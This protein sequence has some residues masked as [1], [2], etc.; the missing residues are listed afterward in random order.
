MKKTLFLIIIALVCI[1]VTAENYQWRG[2]GEDNNW[3][4][5]ANWTNGTSLAH[6]TSPT[7]GDYI[8]L[9]S[10][11][12]A[13]G[14]WPVVMSG[15]NCSVYHIFM[16]MDSAAGLANFAVEN[17]ATLG[18]TPNGIHVGYVDDGE[19]NT[20]GNVTISGGLFLGDG[21]ADWGYAHGTMNVS[22]GIV[23]SDSLNFGMHDSSGNYVGGDGELF[24]MAGVLDAQV[25][26]G[27]SQSDSVIDIYG[28]EFKL[29]GDVRTEINA[30]VESK[31]IRGYSKN[32]AIVVAYDSGSNK[33]IISAQLSQV[34]ADINNDAIVD[35]NDLW[36]IV[37]EWLSGGC[38]EAWGDVDGDCDCN[39]SDFALVLGNLGNSESLIL[40]YGLTVSPSG[41]LM[42]DDQPY[43]RA[44]KSRRS[45]CA[46]GRQWFL[47]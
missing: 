43:R 29:A 16:G 25:L 10:G 35:G 47:G 7:S 27:L 19:F 8:E 41:Q 30:L 42:L 40:G 24:L 28:G 17:G 34:Y 38:G 1:N 6:T 2:G 4:T 15:A 22:G 32:G 12:F 5:P 11:D 44:C 23:T 26:R 9:R 14:M 36:K 18:V 3:L 31:K 37:S 45:S 39:A 20:A 46:Y 21:N 13:N 33:T